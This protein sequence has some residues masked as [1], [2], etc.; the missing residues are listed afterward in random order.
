MYNIAHNQK[1]Y[2]MTLDGWTKTIFARFAHYCAH[3]RT[4]PNT[5]KMTTN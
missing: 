1:S 5:V 4:G 3:V 2:R